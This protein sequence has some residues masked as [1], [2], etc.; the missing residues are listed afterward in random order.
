VK[1]TRETGF[2][3]H[4]SLHKCGVRACQP[5]RT[6]GIAF[7]PDIGM[8]KDASDA[9]AGVAADAQGNVYAAQTNSRNLRKYS[10]GPE[11][12]NFNLFPPVAF[13][14]WSLVTCFL[15]L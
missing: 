4:E 7:V 11:F 8:T 9:P 3:L 1:E 15:R 10:K 5:A 12:F 6:K 2:I 14:R 13:R